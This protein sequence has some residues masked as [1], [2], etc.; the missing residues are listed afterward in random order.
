MSW[1]LNPRK[2]SVFPEY[3]DAL[4]ICGALHPLCLTISE[5]NACGVATTYI[6][7][8]EL[9]LYL[10]EEPPDESLNL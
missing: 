4:Y 10:L 5:K 1:D 8:S 9:L 2:V 7:L 3:H 6:R